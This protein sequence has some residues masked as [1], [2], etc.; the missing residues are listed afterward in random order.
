[1][2][3]AGRNGARHVSVF[4]VIKVEE[5]CEK[6]AG[7]AIFNQEG[8][9]LEVGGVE[10]VVEGSVVVD[11]FAIDLDSVLNQL[12]CDLFVGDDDLRFGV[13]AGAEDGPVKRGAAVLIGSF[14]VSSVRD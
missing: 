13:V 1:L 14:Y 9:N 12:V 4:L 2:C 3:D 7:R 10:Q 8:L 11:V 5:C 6:S